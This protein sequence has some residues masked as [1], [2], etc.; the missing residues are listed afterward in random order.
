MSEEEKLSNNVNS[1]KEIESW[2]FSLLPVGVAFLFYIVFILQS[3][4]ENK[5]LFMAIGA[6][7]GFSGLESYWILKGLKSRRVHLVIMG[8]VGIALT[9]AAL[10]FYMSFIN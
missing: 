8:S 7:A 4:F 5:G 1:S 10:Y 3:D 6:A 9:L 2:I